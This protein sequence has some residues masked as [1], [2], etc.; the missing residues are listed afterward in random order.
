VARA[1]AASAAATFLG[2]IALGR[3][4]RA[5]WKMDGQKTEIPRL[6][7]DNESLTKT[8]GDQTDG[9]KGS[10]TERV[11]SSQHSGLPSIGIVSARRSVPR[12]LSE[13]EL[14]RRTFSVSSKVTKI[15]SYVLYFTV[16]DSGLCWSCTR[17]GLSVQDPCT[18]LETLGADLVMIEF[19]CTKLR[20]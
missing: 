9:P 11:V 20:S 2:H 10:V 6:L 8:H 1:A 16:L 15:Y 4:G 18:I 19:R 5:V 12:E 14:R 7:L 3:P 13:R 17:F